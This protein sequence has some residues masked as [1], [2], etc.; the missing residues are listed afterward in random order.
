MAKKVSTEDKNRRYYWLQLKE[1]FFEE[2]TM[3]WLEEQ[4]NGKD[5]VL[6]YLKMCVKSLRS[7][8]ALI[9]TIGE[10][11]IPY[12]EKA[13]SKLTNTN[14]DIVRVALEVFQHIGLIKRLETGEIFLTQINELVGNETI[15]AERKR[16]QRALKRHKGD[17]V[18]TLS[19]HLP[20]EIEIKKDIDIK[21]DSS[22]SSGDEINNVSE[23][24]RAYEDEIGMIT[25]IISED[26]DFYL[27]ELPK[28]IIIKA[29]HSAS[30]RNAKSWIYVKAIL[31][32][33]IKENIKTIADFDRRTKKP[34]NIAAENSKDTKYAD[35]YKN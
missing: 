9:R 22:T 2:D 13:L 16:K 17:I 5:Y 7:D 4:E 28:D 1:D 33:C 35:I 24:A 11:V 6:F 31:E 25:P 18:P 26:V 20:R 29:I 34:D 19:G 15:Y 10:T 23:I 14:I 32:R 12:D 21:I 3:N 27:K 30:M 8:G